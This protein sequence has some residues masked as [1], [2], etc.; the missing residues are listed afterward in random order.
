MFPL[1]ILD[2]SCLK[3]EMDWKHHIDLAVGMRLVY[4]Y[5]KRS[6]DTGLQH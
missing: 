6:L 2:N 3:L 5:L 1:K 4:K